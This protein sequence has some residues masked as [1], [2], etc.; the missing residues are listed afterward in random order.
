MSFYEDKII[1]ALSDD[2]NISEAFAAYHE[3]V[4]EINRILAEKKNSSENMKSALS[5]FDISDRLFGF[6]ISVEKE[7]PEEVLSK[8]KERHG[9]RCDDGFKMDRDLQNKSDLLRDAIQSEG[10][11]IK[12][13]RPGEFSSIKKKRRTWD[14]NVAKKR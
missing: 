6:D 12:D 1:Q 7:L 8:V 2:L 13:S 3:G 5:Y 14:L 10:W 4:K 11:L 9:V